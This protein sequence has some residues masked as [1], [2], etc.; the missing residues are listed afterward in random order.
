MS[1]SIG[2]EVSSSSV[3]FSKSAALGEGTRLGPQSAAAAPVT[4]LM[5]PSRCSRNAGSP[6]EPIVWPMP[7]YHEWPPSKFEHH[8]IGWSSSW[9]SVP[10]PS[11]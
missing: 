4:D 9:P 11:P 7:V 5:P 6:N 10:S 2:F 1:S 3:T 8:A